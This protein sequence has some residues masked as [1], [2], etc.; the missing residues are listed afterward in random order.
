MEKIYVAWIEDNLESQTACQAYLKKYGDDH[1]LEFVL[2]LYSDSESFLASYRYQY[3]VIFMDVMLGEGKMNGMDAVKLLR[4][5]DSLVPVIFVTNMAQLVY[6]GYE[7]KALDYILK[8]IS[9]PQFEMKMKRILEEIDSNIFADEVVPTRSG[10]IVL[11]VS[12]LI[13]IEVI[14]HKVIYHL[15]TGNISS[16]DTLTHC[17]ETFSKYHFLQCNKCYLI[18]PKFI[19]KIVDYNLYIGDDVLTISHPRKKEFV[20]KFMDYMMN[21]EIRI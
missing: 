3:Q 14:S 11:D 21:K 8:P 5:K 15:T 7:V 12:K 6:K 2:T 17:I 10:V 16:Y 9:Y 19:K 1:N 13:Y 4:E 20:E 18:N